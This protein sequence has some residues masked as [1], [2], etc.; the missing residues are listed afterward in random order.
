M[1][2]REAMVKKEIKLHVTVMNKCICQIFA[3]DLE[4]SE[5]SH[6]RF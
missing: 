6:K 4:S 5:G 2:F 1:S 3:N